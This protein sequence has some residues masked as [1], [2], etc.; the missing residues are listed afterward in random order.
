MRTKA[1]SE[2]QLKTL[3]SKT[4]PNAN[5]FCGNVFYFNDDKKSFSYLFS[6]FALSPSL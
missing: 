5:L 6:S 1:I 3:T 4:G 2:L